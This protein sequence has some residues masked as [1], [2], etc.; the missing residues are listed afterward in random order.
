M[1]RPPTINHDMEYS[2]NKEGDVSPFMQAEWEGRV[3]Y[4]EKGS[5][6][7]CPYKD[8]HFKNRWLEGFRHEAIEF[9]D[10]VHALVKQANRLRKGKTK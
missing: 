1:P 5:H 3:A 7:I 2:R 6:E 10:A 9:H 4:L 8:L